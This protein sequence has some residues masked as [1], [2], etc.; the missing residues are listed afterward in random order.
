M[1]SGQL[2]NSRVDMF[3]DAITRIYD[4]RLGDLCLWSSKGRDTVGVYLGCHDGHPD[5]TYRKRLHCFYVANEARSGVVR[6]S[7]LV[8]RFLRVIR[9]HDGSD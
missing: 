8:A 3:N 4:V 6:I 9:R 2:L 7:G 1:S 5:S